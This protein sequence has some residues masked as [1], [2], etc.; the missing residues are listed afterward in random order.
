MT[1]RPGQRVGGKTGKYGVGG[2]EENEEVF[3]IEHEK[4]TKRKKKKKKK[5]KAPKNKL[6]QQD[7]YV[8][9]EARVDA[10]QAGGHTWHG[11]EIE[12]PDKFWELIVPDEEMEARDLNWV[13]PLSYKRVKRHQFIMHPRNRATRQPFD[14]W[15]CEMSYLPLYSFAK[16][17]QWITPAARELGVGSSI[18]LLTQKAFAWLF[19]VLFL[20]NMPLMF[21]YAKGSGDPALQGPQSFQFTDLFAYI[22]LGNMGVSDYTCA[23]L[24]VARHEKVLRF[25]CP[26]GTMRDIT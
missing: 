16:K 19:L 26:F 20:L 1:Y 25:N 24:N 11:L 7:L 22:S 4:I 15:S 10:L 13:G 21:F 14:W 9:Y 6:N 17:S 8:D 5:K 3:G 2:D 12:D 18:F 23:N